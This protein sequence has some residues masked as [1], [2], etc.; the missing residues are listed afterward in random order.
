MYIWDGKRHDYFTH[1]STF[2]PFKTIALYWLVENTG[3]SIKGNPFK[4]IQ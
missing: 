4:S 3:A 1:R 2:L